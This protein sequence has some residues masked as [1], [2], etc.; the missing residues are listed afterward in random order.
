MTPYVSSK[1]WI[2][3]VMKAGVSVG[4]LSVTKA[5][6]ETAMLEGFDGDASLGQ[7]L[8]GVKDRVFVE[9][10]PSGGYYVIDVYG[11]TAIALNDQAEEVLKGKSGP[12]SWL[13]TNVATRAAMA[14]AGD[15]VNTAPVSGSNRSDSGIVRGSAGTWSVVLM[16]VG[17]I[18]ILFFVLYPR[19]KVAER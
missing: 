18:G 10:G 7:A 17:L 4:T 16:T 9:D 13:Q 19:G 5:D 12:Q 14:K 15:A 1:K 2:A 3:P 8:L 11:D 6:G